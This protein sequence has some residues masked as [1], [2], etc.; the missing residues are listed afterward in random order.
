MLVDDLGHE[1]PVIAPPQRICSLVPSLT[2]SMASVRADWLVAATDWCTHP[3]ALAAERIRGTKNP[4]IR[5]IIDLGSDLVVANEEENRELDV[6]RLREAGVPVWVTRIESVEECF[7]SLERVFRQALDVAPPAWIDAARDEWAV[8]APEPTRTAVMPIWR[9]PWMVVGR[10]TFSAD[11]LARLGVHLLDLGQGRYPRVELEQV[12]AAQPDLVVLP[13]E[14]YAFTPGDA[15]D[16]P[17]VPVR[18]VPGRLLTWYGPSL[19]GSREVL[20]ELL[21][22]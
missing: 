22:G 15:A 21:L 3:E 7:T 8:P 18:C 14:P 12:L 10:P 20:K 6:R 4:D 9:D 13:D 11:L 19:C 1:V 2:E 5:R 17:G 16:L